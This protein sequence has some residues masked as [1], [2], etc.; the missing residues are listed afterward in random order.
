MASTRERQLT[1]IPGAGDSA[2]LQVHLLDV[3]L[4]IILASELAITGRTG[5]RSLTGVR[6]RVSLPLVSRWRTVVTVRTLALDVRLASWCHVVCSFGQTLETRTTAAGERERER[7]TQ[8]CV[9]YAAAVAWREHGRSSSLALLR[10]TPTPIVAR[11]IEWRTSTLVVLMESLSLLSNLFLPSNRPDL[12]SLGEDTKTARGWL[13]ASWQAAGAAQLIP[14][15]PC[16]P[17]CP[18]SLLLWMTWLMSRACNCAFRGCHRSAGFPAAAVSL[19]EFLKRRVGQD[20]GCTTCG[21]LGPSP[22]CMDRR[23]DPGSV[24]PTAQAVGR[25]FAS[26]E[27][28]QAALGYQSSTQHAIV[29]DNSC[30]AVA[31]RAATRPKMYFL[32]WIP[33]HSHDSLTPAH[34]LDREAASQSLP[35]SCIE[36]LP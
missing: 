26:Q 11:G 16:Q 8:L 3:S 19:L 21:P 13:Q 4:T 31:R 20:A 7:E 23:P 18:D 12:S 33:T 5:E 1:G 30:L 28:A 6:E 17:P 36:I 24:N 10:R 34:R 2:F 14:R 32:E 22:R 29:K 25:V 9:I 27:A 35:P 15:M